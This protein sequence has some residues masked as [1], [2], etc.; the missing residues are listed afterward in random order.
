MKHKIITIVLWVVTLGALCGLIF[1]SKFV[2]GKLIQHS[3]ARITHQLT[4]QD[5]QQAQHQKANYQANDTTTAN[6]STVLK[7]TLQAN[8]IKPLGKMSIPAIKM[9]N[10]ILNGYGDKGAYMAIGACTMHPQ[11]QMGQGNYALAG[12]YMKSNTVFHSLSRTPLNAKIYLTDLKKIYVYQVDS[13]RTIDKDDVSVLNQTTTPTITLI[14]CVGLNV[15][16]N[17]TCVKGH[18]IQTLPATS[19]NLKQAQLT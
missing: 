9:H 12:H 3:Q 18:L 13:N 14:T 11:E 6:T 17:R 7:N 10:V 19:A 16:P 5:I 2:Q 4:A 1:N 15:T 8:H